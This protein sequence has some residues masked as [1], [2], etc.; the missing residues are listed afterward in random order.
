[1]VYAIKGKN[2]I[3]IVLMLAILLACSILAAD[4][5]SAATIGVVHD[6]GSDGLFVR[7][8]P[9]SSYSVIHAIY[10]GNEVTII[11]KSGDWYKITHNGI[12]G[13]SHSDYIK[14]KDAENNQNDYVYSE[15]FE[16][17]LENEGFPEN[18]KYYLRQIHA[19][20]PNWVFRAHLT[21]INWAD[22]VKKE[23]AV[24][25]NLVHRTAEK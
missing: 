21:N 16:E 3:L 2:L 9:G 22:A 23:R 18:Y 6:T 17:A 5:A 15:D 10:D 8:G 4:N 20:H 12:T 1:M 24:S 25:I 13:Y 11:E 19:N 7:S 14:I